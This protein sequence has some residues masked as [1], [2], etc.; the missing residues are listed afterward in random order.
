M[1]FIKQKINL[2]TAFIG[3]FF[4]VRAFISAALCFSEAKNSQKKENNSRQIILRIIAQKMSNC[5]GG[6]SMRLF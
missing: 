4:I 5:L 6:L 2:L 1:E 3:R